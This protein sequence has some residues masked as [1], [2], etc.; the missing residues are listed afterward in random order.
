MSR[1]IRKVHV[2]LDAHDIKHVPLDEIKM[3]L[4]G[5]DTLIMSGGRNLLSK[6]L[7][8]SREKKVLEL[9]LDKN[10]AYG[11]FKDYHLDIVKQKIDWLILNNYL[12]IEY[13][14]KM[15]LLVFAPKGW[16][17]EVDTYSDEFLAGFDKMLESGEDNFLMTYLKDRNREII[18]ML[19]DKI[20]AT[21]NT[22]YIPILES[23]E[24]IDYKKV[25]KR[26]RQVIRELQR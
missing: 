1:K 7:K 6:L 8:G 16:E 21:K 3:I 11:Y 22:K 13:D 14:Y 20:E 17:I 4:R 5:A 25:R 2:C 18:S 12:K 23:W 24:A 9:G 26:I 19:L 10:P 15:P